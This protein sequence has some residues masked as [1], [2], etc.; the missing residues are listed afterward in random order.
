MNKS[1]TEYKKALERLTASVI[2]FEKALEKEMLK[3]PTPE[4]G[5]RI[6]LLSNFLTMQNQTVMRFTLDYSLKKI[7]RLYSASK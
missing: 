6:A 5:R 3:P 4:R 2:S 1:A 7:A